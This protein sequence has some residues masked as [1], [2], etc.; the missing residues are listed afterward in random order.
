MIYG[1]NEAN[2]WKELWDELSSLR[3]QMT[4]EVWLLADD[5]NEIKMPM[6]R[7]IHVIFNQIGAN[8][9]NGMIQGLTKL[10]S[11]GGFHTWANEMGQHT[12]KVAWIV[13]SVMGGGSARGHSFIQDYTSEP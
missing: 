9:F 2:K 5:F 8:D 4:N 3:N 10:G 1:A 13:L 12:T 6:E 11:V 7:D